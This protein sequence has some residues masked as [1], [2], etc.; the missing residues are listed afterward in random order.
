MEK[1]LGGFCDGL[2]TAEWKSEEWQ[3]INIKMR[4]LCEH[5]GT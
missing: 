4:A 3:N 1:L 2:K 5:C